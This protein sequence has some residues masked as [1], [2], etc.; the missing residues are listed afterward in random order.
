MLN[1][2]ICTSN[3]TKIK[4]KTIAT[5]ERAIEKEVVYRSERHKKH[6]I[7]NNLS[8]DP[9]FFKCD[10]RNKIFEEEGIDAYYKYQL[11]NESTPLEKGTGY[12]G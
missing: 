10:L 7:E 11:D 12:R 3:T 8:L 6:M 1:L 2:H 5:L 4:N 9:D